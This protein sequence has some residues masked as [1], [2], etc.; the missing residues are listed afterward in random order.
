MADGETEPPHIT[1]EPPCPLAQLGAVGF[2]G[3]GAVGSTLTRLLAACGA[4]I[5]M[6]SAR[7]L[8]HVWLLTRALPG[9]TQVGSPED[10]VATCD[11][12]FL[13]VPDDAITPLAESLPWR[14]GQGVVHLSGAHSAAA[15]AA[16]VARG[17]HPAALHPLMTFPRYPIDA[18]ITPIMERV[19]GCT[20]ALEAEDSSLT[21][22]LEAI[23]AALDGR[24]VRLAAAD[25]VPYHISGVLASNYVAAL[26]GAG[27]SLWQGFGVDRAEAVAAL[28]P[29]LRATVESLADVGLPGALTGPV[30][31]GDAGTVAAHLAWLDAHAAEDPQIA[32]LR[33]AYVALARL[34]IP[35][36]RQKG[37]LSEDAT[38]RLEALLS[39]GSAGRSV[40]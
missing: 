14:T 30:A 29:L 24:I 31:R 20:W 9:H 27:A 4:D 17:A 7:H 5:R 6:V 25:R 26:V 8:A 22:Q 35:I 16:C 39:S 38:V 10:V 2:I 15:L 28:L 37:T 11:L 32:T 12:V 21:G 19:G 36:A 33:D 34:A 3:A 18:P 23:V 1:E 40:R 13:A